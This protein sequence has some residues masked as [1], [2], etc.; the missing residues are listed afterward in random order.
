MKN[1]SLCFLSFLFIL[2]ACG[3]GG[4]KEGKGNPELVKKAEKIA[5]LGCACEDV[6]CLFDIKVDGEGV[7]K[8]LFAKTD[9]L[10]KEEKELFYAASRKYNECEAALSKKK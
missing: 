7:T 9:D 8:I 5:E 2:A 10:T 3:G 1:V 6:K 4:E